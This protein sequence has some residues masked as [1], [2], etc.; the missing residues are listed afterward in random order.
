M[1][2]FSNHYEQLKTLLNIEIE[3]LSPKDKI[4][5]GYSKANIYHQKK[6][7]KKSSYFLKI[8]NEEK[9]KIQPS[10]IKRKL[11]TG[12]Y[13]R[14]LKIGKNLNLERITDND[15]YLFIVGMPRCGSTLLESILSLNSEVQDL[16]EVSFLEE[17]LHKTDDLIEVQN[18][19]A[20]K[21]KLINSEKKIFTDKNLFNF[22]YCPVINN[23]FPNARIIHCTRNP[24]DNILSIYRTNFL[25]QSFSSSLKD[26][27]DI[28]LYQM[29]IMHEYKSKFGSIIYNYDHD[30]VVQNPEETIKNLINWL[31]WEWSDNYLSPQKSKR[32]VFTASSVQVR[33]KINSYSSGY[34]KNYKDLLK[35]I[36][37]LFPTYN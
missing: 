1:Y 5:F 18:L 14:N 13:Y 21:V 12:E 20:E 32:S 2:N 35:P 6:E 26:I 23:F 34:W 15:R 24:L 9:L 17:S 4:Y 22:L 7:Y 33:E 8:A 3:N 29:K 25:N 30:K 31:D 16:G 36:S 10:D 37:E 27:T 11:N 28:Y 19:Y